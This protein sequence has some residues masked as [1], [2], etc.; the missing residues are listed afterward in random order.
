MRVLPLASLALAAFPFHAFAQAPP[1]PPEYIRVDRLFDSPSGRYTGPAVLV[2]EDARIRSVEAAGFLVPPGATVVDGKTNHVTLN[3]YLAEC[4]NHG[5]K[6]LQSFPEQPPADTA[7]VCN[8]QKDPNANKQYVI[9][10]KV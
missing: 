4:A 3:V 9:D 1:A 5:F 2:V 10:V 6:V 8:L 7:S